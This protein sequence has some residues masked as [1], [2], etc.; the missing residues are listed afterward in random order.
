MNVT[1]VRYIN[2]KYNT[3]TVLLTS[4]HK[5]CSLLLILYTTD[6]LAIL[7]YLPESHS[8]PSPG[9]S[10]SW[11]IALASRSMSCMSSVPDSVWHKAGSYPLSFIGTVITRGDRCP[12]AVQAHRHKINNL[13][14]A[15]CGK[16]L[17]LT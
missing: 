1:V 12:Q 9:L 15:S 5:D 2:L 6:I 10:P 7:Y 3:C 14:I 4:S 17:I 11:S 8:E 13:A 16:M